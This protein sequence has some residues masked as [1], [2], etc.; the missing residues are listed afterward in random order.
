[1]VNEMKKVGRYLF[2]KFM[3]SQHF[4]YGVQVLGI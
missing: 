4:V 2:G 3:L 1:M